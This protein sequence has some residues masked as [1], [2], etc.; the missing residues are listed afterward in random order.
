[1]K[2]LEEFNTDRSKQIE[3]M[4]SGKPRLNGIQCPTEGCEAQ[5]YD[6]EPWSTLP[7]NPPK[8]S[9]HCVICGFRGYRL[10]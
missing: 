1:V 7:S 4:E 5:L 9:I 8:K 3:R 2:T 6:S 10:A